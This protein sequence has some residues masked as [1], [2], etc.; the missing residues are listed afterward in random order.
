MGQGTEVVSRSCGNCTKCCD[1]WLTGNIRGHDVFPGK[2]CFFVTIG[3]GCNDYHN[4][5][6][7]CKSF[8]CQWLLDSN[9]PET[10]KPSVSDIII[11]KQDIDEIEYIK[12]VE[13]GNPNA[14]NLKLIIDYYSASNINWWCEIDQVNYVNGSEAFMALVESRF[15]V[16]RY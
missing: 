15:S 2:P 7:T 8:E 16:S 13:A 12:I 11:T 6:H 9:I 14:E 5:P 10:L 1:G 4:R 3:V